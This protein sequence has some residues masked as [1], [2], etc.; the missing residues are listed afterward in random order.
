MGTFFCDQCNGE[1][2]L[3]MRTTYICPNC[4]L[5]LLDNTQFRYPKSTEYIVKIK[6]KQKAN[7]E[8]MKKLKKARKANAT[9][10]SLKKAKRSSG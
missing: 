8:D 4:N 2:Y 3:P 9:T 7:K 10:R 1:F 5:N 6:E